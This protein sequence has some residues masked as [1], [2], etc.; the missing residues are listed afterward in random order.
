[1]NRTLHDALAVQGFI[2][3]QVVI[4]LPGQASLRLPP[5][6]GRSFASSIATLV[7][8]D[9]PFAS[10]SIEGRCR[11]SLAG[12]PDALRISDEVSAVLLEC[13]HQRHP[14]AA[15]VEHYKAAARA[16]GTR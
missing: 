11:D 10:I 4:T 2:Q 1:M 7:K 16:G 12:L 13:R 14:G 8:V 15:L 9:L 5:V 3:S 6:V